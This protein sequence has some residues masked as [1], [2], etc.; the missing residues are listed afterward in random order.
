MVYVVFSKKNQGDPSSQTSKFFKKKNAWALLKH[1]DAASTCTNFA[2][3]FSQSTDNY[4]QNEK[5]IVIR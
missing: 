5:K 3:R 4:L 1:G 2:S